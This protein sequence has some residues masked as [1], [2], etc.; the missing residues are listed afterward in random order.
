MGK[1][2]C[3]HIM[4]MFRLPLLIFSYFT[5]IGC[6]ED[7]PVYSIFCNG[8]KPSSLECLRYAILDSKDKNRI[9]Q[10]L[11]I[12]NNTK[13]SYRVELTKYHVGNCNNPIV[14]SRGSD[15]NGYVRIEI[16]KGFKCYYKIQ[17]DYKDDVNRAFERVIKKIKIDLDQ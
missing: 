10:A 17:S 7:F 13:C 1:G 14:K 6:Q 9:E 11:G 16:K 8:K 2:Y 15:F 5:F 3:K 4:T 12:K